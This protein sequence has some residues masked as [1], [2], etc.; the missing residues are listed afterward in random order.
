VEV[1]KIE[2]A[3][4]AAP[5]EVALPEDMHFW[6]AEMFEKMAKSGL[7]RKIVIA[8][9]AAFTDDNFNTP[10]LNCSPLPTA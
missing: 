9:P 3:A 10:S 6:T 1:A 4:A 8:S 2:I 5:T 7:H